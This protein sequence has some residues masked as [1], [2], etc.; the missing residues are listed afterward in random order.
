MRN[1][2]KKTAA[3]LLAFTLAA[4]PL[5]QTGAKDGLFGG[6]SIVAHAISD[7]MGDWIHVFDHDSGTLSSDMACTD[8]EVSDHATLTIN[9]GITLTLNI[10]DYF[11]L[12]DN[13]KIEL[14]GELAG[15]V[16]G[17]YDWGEDSYIN[18]YLSDGAKYTVTGLSCEDGDNYLRYYGYDAATDGNGTV[19]VKN[20]DTAV[21]SESIGYKTTT[22][23]YTATPASGY[24]FKNWTKGAGG[25]VI[26]TDASI[27]VTCEQNGQY[28]VYANFEEDV[29]AP[30]MTNASVTLG[31]DLAL[32]F[33]VDNIT[34]ATG[35]TVMFDGVCDENGTEV[36]LT[37]KDGKFF[38]TANVNAKDFKENIAATLYKD[39]V[40]TDVTLTS[41][42]DAYLTALLATD[43]LDD[44]TKAMVT[45]AQLYGLA[46]D[47]YFNETD[48]NVAT[49]IAAYMTAANINDT[50]LNTAL[51]P[52]APTFTSD[53]A[54]VSMV[55]NSKIKLRVYS[56]NGAS[57]NGF[58]KYSEAAGLTPLTLAQPQAI[59]G[60][61]VSG[62][63]WVYRVLNNTASEAK[64]VNMAKA[65][66]AYMTAAEALNAPA[67]PAA[68]PVTAITLN[69][70]ATTIQAGQTET[71]SVSSVTPDD[72]TDKTV[73]WSSDNEAVA[74]VNATTGE[75]TAVALGTANI[76]ATANDGSGVTATCAVTVAP[77]TITVT[78]NN[79][80]ITGTDTYGTSFT[81]DG[82]TITA[83]EI[84][85]PYKNFM[86]GGTFTTTLGNFTKIE[87][88]T[89]IWD[90]SGA[91][92]IGSTWTGN[93][94][95]VSFSDNIVGNG[96][97]NTKFVFT[98][99]PTN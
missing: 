57:E 95:S 82:V 86:N 32:N 34:D 25:E 1:T 18:V 90:A 65:L 93:A 51:T 77:A 4:V 80:D 3:F 84:Y 5:S 70:T 99:A 40:A 48:N 64:D 61:T 10:N 91:G 81:K 20:G 88:T 69:K 78:W 31:D 49:R 89:G 54:K 2:W 16:S 47:E 33:Y 12:F 62:Y 23:T 52:Y 35:Y 41:S 43:G 83:D 71:L 75:V 66:F 37:E 14:H 94:S 96:M 97:G 58:G 50:A 24:K 9:K 55:L 38:A 7:I 8:L 22:Y 56:D 28:Q 36:A 45:S 92:W 67:V 98:I 79:D 85:F 26:G 72:A 27:D 87:V 42:V 19:G 73:T 17:D 74:T 11:E 30:T 76:T 29:V 59:D 15:S 53:D 44:K 60:F 46:A 6:R 13:S 68:T 21:T 63:T 39:G